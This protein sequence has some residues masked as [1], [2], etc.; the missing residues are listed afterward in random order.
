M[1]IALSGRYQDAVAAQRQRRLDVGQPVADPPRAAEVDVEG[2]L[3]VEEQLGAGLP[4]FAGS[5]EPGMVRAVPRAV[6]VPAVALE[7]L[8][9]AALHGG[10][11]L[12]R[13]EPAR[14]TRLIADDD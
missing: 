6:D 8:D 1:E 3:G 9:D 13:I 11:V 14:D 7:Q 2:F 10:V 4:A 12:H 5:R